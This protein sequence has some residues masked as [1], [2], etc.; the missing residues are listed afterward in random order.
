MDRVSLTDFRLDW[1]GRIVREIGFSTGLSSTLDR[2]SKRCDAARSG[3]SLYLD[4]IALDSDLEYLLQSLSRSEV[5]IASGSL[6]IFY[7]ALEE[8]EVIPAQPS[9]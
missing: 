7:N 6:L 3:T 4:R 5:A 2:S 9:S 8:S 1:V